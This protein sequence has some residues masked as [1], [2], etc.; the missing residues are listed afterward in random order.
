MYEHLTAEI[1]AKDP[2]TARIIRKVFP[3]SDGD[4]ENFA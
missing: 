3:R 1:H 2:A 4:F